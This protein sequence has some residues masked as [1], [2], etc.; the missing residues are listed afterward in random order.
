MEKDGATLEEALS[1]YPGL[2]AELEP[3]LSLPAEMK[4]MPKIEAPASLR[5][6]KR[7]VFRGPA[8]QARP[9]EGWWRCF[10]PAAG[11]S[12]GWA[13]PL[14]RIAA[15]LA[16]VTVAASGAIVT[17]ASSLPDEPLYPVKLAMENAQLAI[18]PNDQARADLELQ[19]AA[20][21]VGEV[22]SAAQQDNPEAVAL[23]VVL[24]EQGVDA[25]IKAYQAASPSALAVP[26]K[27]QESLRQNQ[28]ALSEVL[29][30]VENPKAKDAIQHAMAVSAGDN[31]GHDRGGAPG[32]RP[33]AQPV[34]TVVASPSP[35][36]AA[37][38]IMAAPVPTAAT[39]PA[40]GN[41]NG[42][43]ENA[44]N[45]NRGDG[46][47]VNAQGAGEPDGTGK[48]EDKSDK[49][50][51]GQGMQP[52]SDGEGESSNTASPTATATP[53]ATPLT[54][55]TATPAPTSTPVAAARDG[56]GADG[57]GHEGVS[58]RGVQRDLEIGPSLTATPGPDNGRGQ[59][60]VPGGGKNKKSEDAG[61]DGLSQ[62]V[63][64][65]IL[66]SVRNM[67]GNR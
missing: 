46:A 6:Y 45:P 5:G 63:L 23:G 59:G 47:A 48:N 65:S 58:G 2:R 42:R 66:G 34:A 56:S 13:T 49:Q 62:D 31:L 61:K 11:P 39:V 19:F 38:P 29:G 37:T 60:D 40:S 10:L 14:A 51:R 21:R 50:R 15:V 54:T 22:R 55:A 35:T 52:A 67:V 8:E 26:E 44:G 41:T 16:I 4:A 33:A 57:R 25:A 53:A 28:Q 27:V 17:S 1:L 64:S 24:Y 7:P 30:K 3:L 36:T 32:A 18:A 12:L 9:R 20:K 43:P